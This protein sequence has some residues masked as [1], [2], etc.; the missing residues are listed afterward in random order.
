MAEAVA[1]TNGSDSPRPLQ[2]S[3]SISQA[4]DSSQTAQEFISSQLQLEADAREALP[5]QFDSCTRPLGPLRQLLF[6]CL[7]CNPPPE[8]P[9]APYKPAGVCYSCSISCHGEHNLVELFNKRDF[10]CDCGTTR[11]PETSPCT[12]RINETTSQKGNLHSEKAAEANRYNQNFRN[13]FCGCSENYDAHSEKGTMFQCLGLGTAEEGGCGEDWWHAECIVGLPRGWYKKGLA[14]KIKPETNGSTTTALEPIVEAETNGDANGISGDNAEMEDQFEE[15][16]PLPPGFPQEDDFEAFICYKC[17]EAFPWI[18][19]YAGTE[20]F[21]PAVLHQNSS[22]SATTE[23]AIPPAKVEEPTESPPT[24]SRKRKASPDLEDE[25]TDSSIKRQRSTSNPPPATSDLNATNFTANN[26][27]AISP[28]CTYTTLPTPP[29]STLS[30]FLTEDFRQHLCRCPTH[31]P[32]LVPHPG[33]LDEEENYE[34]PI[35]ENGSEAGGGSGTAS[36]YD[37]GEAAL[38]NMDRVRALE[39]VMAYNHVKDKVKDFL[40]PYADSG[41]MVGAEDIKKYFEGLRGDADALKEMRNRVNE[42][43]GA[44]G[45]D[46]RREQGGY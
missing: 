32:L 9:S 39:G 40:K 17:V 25:P 2:R 23:G 1:K 43:E 15:D 24:E 42:S 18:K 29:T 35:S 44:V 45:G 30:L 19:R 3:G 26:T 31:F 14:T 34:P 37:R 20:G 22:E 28:T 7:T 21:L 5:Y 16:P 12:L 13:R 38:N 10:V 11:L 27:A 36:L 33:L 6:S 8:D 4:S 46:G 41:K